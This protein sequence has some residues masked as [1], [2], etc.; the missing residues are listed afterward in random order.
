MYDITANL[1]KSNEN[2]SQIIKTYAHATLITEVKFSS[3]SLGKIRTL[4]DPA[5]IAK[6]MILGGAKALSVLTQPN[7]FH[8]SPEYFIKIRQSTDAPIL[9]K[10]ITINK[11]QIEAGQKMGA[12]FILLIQSIFDKGYVKEMDEFI[13]Y[14]HKKNMEVLLEVHTRKEFENALKTEADLIGI[15]N[16]DLD[17]LEIDLQT[18]KKVLSS[19]DKKKPIV[20]ESGIENPD[21]IRYLKKCGADAFLVGSSIMKSDN[22]QDLVKN[23]VNAY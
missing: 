17:T 9:M 3:P 19:Y 20:A 1:Q 14:V 22:I 6:S 21:D 8:G 16:R 23:L 7:L 4:T 18:T 11:V 13:D 10:D 2:L 12:D 5:S 15:N